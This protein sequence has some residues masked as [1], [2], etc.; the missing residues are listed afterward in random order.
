MAMSDP[1]LIVRAPSTLLVRL[2]GRGLG[3]DFVMGDPHGMIHLVR[4]ALA[5]LDFNPAIDRLFIV[6][7]LV[8]RGP[9]SDEALELLNEPW[10]FCVRGNHEQCFLDCYQGG[11]LNTAALEFHVRENGGAWWLALSEERR[12]A[13]LA[14]YAKMPLVIEVDTVR[15]TVGM[16]HAEVPRGMDWATFKARIEAGDHHT[17]MS[18]LWGRTRAKNND[19]RGVHGIGR[20]YSG[21][22]ILDRMSRLG[23]CYMLDTGA[24]LSLADVDDGKLSVTDMI[25]STGII[26]GRPT[27][28]SWF[29]GLIQPE[30]A[31]F[32]NYSKD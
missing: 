15:G 13:H 20:I 22:T 2:L 10:C 28:S 29:G 9:Y 6:G 3:R 4:A 19:H 17:T 7:D 26:T 1:S 16:V 30:P 25:A 32:G 21:H 14:A 18:A 24:F 23:N 8:D 31:P 11:R 12:Q 5:R 27:L